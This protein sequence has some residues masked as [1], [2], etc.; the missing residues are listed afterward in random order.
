MTPDPVRAGDDRGRPRLV[1]LV[2]DCIGEFVGDS[3]VSYAP[4]PDRA[5]GIAAL[6]L[7]LVE[8]AVEY[9]RDPCVGELADVL[10]V[11]QALASKDLGCGWLELNDEAES[12]TDERGGFT[13]LVGM[14]VQTTTPNRH[15][16]HR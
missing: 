9:L 8:E 5:E 1:K 16:A 4:I 11:V 2:R 14:Y 3:T 12:K 15:E 13:D 6:R 7:K 10:A